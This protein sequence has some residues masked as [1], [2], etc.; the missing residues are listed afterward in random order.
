MP[1]SHISLNAGTHSTTSITTT[2]PPFARR[3]AGVLF[4]GA[5]LALAATPSRVVSG[6]AVASE[7]EG[8]RAEVSGLS[9]EGA[10]W[11]LVF[12]AG[13]GG[14]LQSAL[15]DP[16]VTATFQGG[17]LT[18]SAGCNSYTATYQLN[19]ERL[20]LSRPASTRRLC[21]EPEVMTQESTYLAALERV[22]RYQIAGAGLVLSDGVGN[23][24]LVYIPQPQR[25]LQGTTWEAEAYNNGRGGVV[26]L[27]A[28]TSITA[29]FDGTRLTGNAGCNQYSA[30]YE[31]DGTAISVGE[32]TSTRRACLQPEGVMEQERAYLTALTTARV[33]RIEGKRLILETEDG[34]RVASY[35]S[36]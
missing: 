1:R 7:H 12:Y 30:A 23:P 20:Q 2:S 5:V 10:P 32:P 14:Q 9:L 18:G 36:R 11:T 15:A 28:G 27:I 22:S 25:P 13:S 33:Y 31:T 21:G 8:G 19:G 34:A 29:Q 35:S 24:L 3:R 26:S 16:E 17:R 6:G 4:A